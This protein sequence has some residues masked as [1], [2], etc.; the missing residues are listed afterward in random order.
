MDGSYRFD[1][2][3]ISLGENGRLAPLNRIRQHLRAL[4]LPDLKDHGVA[5]GR[6]VRG[7]SGRAG[8]LRERM[9]P[10][11]R[12][13]LQFLG[14]ESA[15]EEPREP[16]QDEIILS[17]FGRLSADQ[18]R[19][20]ARNLALLWE[21]FVEE[22]DGLSGFIQSPPTEQAAYLQKLDA[23]AARMEA[24]RV[25]EARYHFVS[26]ALMKRYVSLFLEKSRDPSSVELSQRVA[27]LID[28]SHREGF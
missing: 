6:I 2:A 4:S 3:A 12:A 25:A 21:C 17:A 20:V 14:V 27:A 24:S 16:T 26:V 10:W 23:A 11:V 15:D 19:S 5:L 18:K 28:G 7:A 8:P 13:H 1:H 9:G 22:F